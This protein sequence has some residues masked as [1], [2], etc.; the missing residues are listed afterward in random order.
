MQ[1]SNFEEITLEEA[2]RSLHEAAV[3]EWNEHLAEKNTPIYKDE[4]ETPLLRASSLPM[5]GMEI[6]DYNDPI[7]RRTRER[8]LHVPIMSAW[9]KPMRRISKPFRRP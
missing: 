6:I 3:E 1:N 5:T 7:L 2:T 9:Q 4:V 8:A